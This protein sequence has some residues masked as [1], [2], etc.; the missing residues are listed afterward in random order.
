MGYLFSWRRG[1]AMAGD[2]L[3]PALFIIGAPGS[4]GT[5]WTVAGAPPVPLTAIAEEDVSPQS[6]PNPE[7]DLIP[8]AGPHINLPRK[9][10]K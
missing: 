7:L 3:L 4:I 8:E 2:R 10:R 5:F 1:S 9:S 6:F